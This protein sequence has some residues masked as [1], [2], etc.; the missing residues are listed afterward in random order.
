MTFSPINL[1]LIIKLLLLLLIGMGPKI[2]LVPFLEKTSGFDIA[3]QRAIGRK[4]V[5]TAVIAALI[6]YATGWLLL[7]LLHISQGA[8]AVA[9]GI[10][11]AI[12][13]IEMVT[14]LGKKPAEEDK[15]LEDTEKIP[16]LPNRTHGVWGKKGLERV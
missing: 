2:A 3:T 13:A 6:L 8:V 11:F 12:I 1:D 4:M 14:G 10:I 9:G 15:T 7:R 16:T 5:T